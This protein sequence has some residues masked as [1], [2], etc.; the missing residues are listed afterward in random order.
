MSI[1]AVV[2]TQLF[3]SLILWWIL[4]AALRR[5]TGKEAIIGRIQQE[6][7][8][9]VAD[10]NEAADQNITILEDR[11]ERLRSEI[12]TAE[13]LIARIRDEKDRIVPAPIVNTPPPVEIEIS[14]EENV[15]TRVIRL[16]HSGLSP[17]LIASTCGITAGEVQLMLSLHDRKGGRRAP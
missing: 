2:L 17:E 12:D 9:L 4:M 6:V 7:D 16:H 14:E 8:G 5:R 13:A 15:Q 10:L 1:G 11:L 3:F